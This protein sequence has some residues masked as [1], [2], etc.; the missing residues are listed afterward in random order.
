MIRGEAGARPVLP[1]L[2]FTDAKHW[3]VENIEIAGHEGDNGIDVTGPD[4][5]DMVFSD[6]LLHHLSTG[7]KF[8]KSCRIL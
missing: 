2:R 5:E 4:S 8:G 7:I 6:L 3:R 1:R